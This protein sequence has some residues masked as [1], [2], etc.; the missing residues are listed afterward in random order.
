MPK[1][2][3]DDTR[4]KSE[5][6][7][8]L[9]SGSKWFRLKQLADIQIAQFFIPKT[10]ENKER[11]TTDSTFR[12][13]LNQGTQILDR[14]ESMAIS[15]A[16]RFF[17][18]F[19]EFPEVVSSGGFDCI[20]GNPPYLG[21]KKLKNA[22]GEAF[23]HHCRSHYVGAG[24][25]DLVVYFYRRI[26]ELI[27][28]DGFASLI[29]TDSI[30][31]G[32]LRTRAL[33]FIIEKGGK[34]NFAI[35]S[36]VWPGEANTNVALTTFV[37]DSNRIHASFIGVKEVSEINSFLVEGEKE[38][39]PLPLVSNSGLMNMGYYFLGDGFLLSTEEAKAML[40][41]NKNEQVIFPCFKGDDLNSM[42]DLKPRRFIINFF[43]WSLEKAEEYVKPL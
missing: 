11:L 10:T 6:Y 37:R 21:D 33:S 27:S 35:K 23:V 34:L 25:N 28:P 39:E 15:Q 30:S 40:N 1:S 19:L 36:L 3:P 13:Y 41:D 42:A 12:T 24:V 43:D 5:A 8:K 18:W 29:S 14:G 32:D 26:F 22:F 9:T 20:L 38:N 7:T 4:A 2:T 31:E 17:H 16:K